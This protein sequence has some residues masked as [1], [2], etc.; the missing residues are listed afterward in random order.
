MDIFKYE[1]NLMILRK[2]RGI[3]QT[4]MAQ[5]LGISQTAYSRIERHLIVAGNDQISEI[6]KILDVPETK[7]KHA[8]KEFEPRN[9]QPTL[10]SD[11]IFG[12]NTNEFLNS[13]VGIIVMLT[14][15]Y[16]LA[17]AAYD[18][19]RGACSALETSN[20][21]MMFV[22]WTAALLTIGYIYYLYRKAKK[23]PL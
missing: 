2:A 21:T 14:T 23:S 8:M 11:S 3:S 17:K 20:S 15:T 4:E 9:M 18:A 13:P 10:E 6:A 5:R 1:K 7:L 12:H 22:S 19:A 16:V